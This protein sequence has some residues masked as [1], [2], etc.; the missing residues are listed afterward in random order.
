MAVAESVGDAVDDDR[1][2]L[3]VD[4]SKEAAV[5]ER[6]FGMARDHL[7]LELELHHRGRLL[8][9]RHHHGLAQTLA[10]RQEALGGIVGVDRPHQLLERLN[11]DAVALF[12]LGEAAIARGDAE[13]VGDE[14]I[15][16][17][18]GA[19]PG[20]IV[21]APGDRHVRLLAQV[22]DHPVAARSAVDAVAGHDQLAHREVADH[23]HDE[24]DEIRLALLLDQGLH[25]G[26]DVSGSAFG[27]RL[28]EHLAEDV[29]VAFA[30]ARP[31]L[32]AG[33]SD[34]RGRGGSRA[35]R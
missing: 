5:I 9:P 15:V 3:E 27:E 21:I 26:R 23:A 18:R 12:E 20:D 2:R 14:S 24:A 29:R 30:E 34:R 7:S 25:D 17:E 11:G 32:F 28:V 4:R 16:A 8:H 19:E 10:V 31:R 13:D 33:W 1:A 22:F 35:G 6:P